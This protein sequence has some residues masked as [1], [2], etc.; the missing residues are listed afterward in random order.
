MD[1]MVEIQVR[2]TLANLRGEVH[3]NG[4]TEAACEMWSHALTMYRRAKAAEGIELDD[5]ASLSMLLRPQA[6]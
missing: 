1:N 2:T 3:A 6:G 4:I 5:N